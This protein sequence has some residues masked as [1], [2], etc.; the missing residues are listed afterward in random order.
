MKNKKNK[1]GLFVAAALTA[2]GLSADA[3][4][5]RLIN[6]GGG[7]NGNV[8]YTLSM[9][10]ANFK[11]SGGLQI[12]DL[13]GNNKYATNKFGITTN[14]LFVAPM[15][16]GTNVLNNSGNWL[17]FVFYLGGTNSSSLTS[18][19]TFPNDVLITSKLVGQNYTNVTDVPKLIKEGA[20]QPYGDLFL[21]NININGINPYATNYLAFTRKDSS[22]RL[23]QIVD[24]GNGTANI[25][26]SKVLPSETI[27]L[28]YND[29]LNTTNWNPIATNYVPVTAENFNSI[30]STT[31]TNLPMTNYSRFYRTVTQ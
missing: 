20:N 25:E 24:N 9:N 6:Y 30:T 28:Q 16:F 4:T 10:N 27:V 21:P 31:F 26:V 23:Q 7:N 18:S 17:R 3:Q 8:N 1:L 5:L 13:Q 2:S 19:N 15:A 11:S 29:N 22:S 14:N 12:Y